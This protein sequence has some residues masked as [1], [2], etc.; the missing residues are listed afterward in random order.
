LSLEFRRIGF[1]TRVRHHIAVSFHSSCKQ[2][3]AIPQ[4]I[5]ECLGFLSLQT[6]GMA[7]D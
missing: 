7:E 5:N 3:T 2:H 4:N 1:Q 6:T